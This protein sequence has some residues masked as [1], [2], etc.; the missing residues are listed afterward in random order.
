LGS[1]L[2]DCASSSNDHASS[3]DAHALNEQLSI[4]CENLLSKYKF[5]EHNFIT[6][7]YSNLSIIC[8]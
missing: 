5:D 8:I 2:D 1:H 6:F 7:S 4:F 3:M